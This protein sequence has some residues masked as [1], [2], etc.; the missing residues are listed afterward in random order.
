VSQGPGEPTPLP[1]AIE[2][3]PAPR[4]PVTAE[5][6]EL[7]G[8]R[9]PRI[10][11]PV[12]LKRLRGEVDGIAIERFVREARLQG[13]LEHPAV[14]P[15]LDLGLDE[16]GRPYFVMRQVRG[17]PLSE[18][19]AR[20][21]TGD[22]EAERRFT[23]R[24]LL[25]A[26]VDI[27]LAVEYAH[28]RGV[29]H[30][31]LRPEHIVLGDFRE[32]YV[33]EWGSARLLDREGALR[34]EGM[35]PALPS[36]TL[37]PDTVVWPGYAA[38]EQLTREP[39]I[40]GRADVY[41]LGCILFEILCGQPLHGGADAFEKTVLG[42]HVHA[43]ARAA[44]RHGPPEL[45]DACAA[46]TRRLDERT[47]SARALGE[48][49]QRW[50]DG[51]R[52]LARRRE[53][54][55]RHRAR[56]HDA[57]AAGD[58][59]GAMREAGAAVALV[60]ADEEAATLLGRLVLEPPG[61]DSPEGA[62]VV[63]ES[64]AGEVRAQARVAVLSYLAVPAFLPLLAWLGIQR[65]G[66]VLA[67]AAVGLTQAVIAWAA[68]RGRLAGSYVWLSTAGNVVMLALGSRIFG[69][70]LVVPGMAVMIAMAALALPAVRPWWLVPVLLSAGVLTPSL[71]EA[72][73]L[74]AP[75]LQLTGDAVVITSDVVALPRGPTVALL[76]VYI[77]V[78]LVVAVN[79][80]RTLTRVNREARLRLQSQAWHLAQ[81]AQG[82][83][84]GPVGP[85]EPRAPTE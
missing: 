30:R 48:A 46:A 52:D 70:L 65:A 56:A 32:V 60:P 12:A 11:R 28:T 15:V 39:G 67:L 24:R 85:A 20:R 21:A 6:E 23:N 26:F 79:Y 74:L 54:A 19:L 75:T 5:G 64:D 47:A 35:S 16:S 83:S 58:R 53:L 9:D 2:R 80:G 37:G 69:P 18:I 49:V 77:V 34:R 44:G 43:A 17:T 68:M 41:A 31:D 55:A 63:A 82:D 84:S 73:G 1:L 50:L 61:E 57:L 78:L 66:P 45:L 14:V 38:P 8:A 62:A 27:C 72:A 76:A 71:L 42:T 10:G 36:A 59:L 29:V 81:L 40:D 7:A 3:D 25:A 22:G 4:Y 51:V 13:R 33:R